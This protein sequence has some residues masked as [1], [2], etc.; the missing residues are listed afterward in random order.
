M[1]EERKICSTNGDANEDRET[2]EDNQSS[3]SLADF[4]TQNYAEQR[5]AR[6]M[7]SG[8]ANPS[9]DEEERADKFMERALSESRRMNL[10]VA[11]SQRRQNEL[12]RELGEDKFHAWTMEHA[13][14]VIVTLPRDGDAAVVDVIAT[15][16]DSSDSGDMMR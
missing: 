10:E 15:D 6:Q 12:Y 5:E 16:A 13:S 3:R 11:R 4:V 2:G 14:E 1:A 9:T 7:R 8:V